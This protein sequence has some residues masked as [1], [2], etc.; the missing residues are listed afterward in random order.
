MHRINFRLFI[1]ATDTCLTTANDY[2]AR[3]EDTPAMTWDAELAKEAKI[4]AGKSHVPYSLCQ[5]CAP[6]SLL[7]PFRF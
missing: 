2:R 3:H 1:L 7:T 6:Y 5:F 4:Y